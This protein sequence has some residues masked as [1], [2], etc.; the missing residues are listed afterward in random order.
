MRGSRSRAGWP[1]P[2]AGQLTGGS[3]TLPSSTPGYRFHAE[4]TGRWQ[5]VPAARLHHDP[6]AAATHHALETA[7][8]AARLYPLGEHQA[9]QA[10]I[11][12]RLGAGADL[13]DA[14]VR[15]LW[16]EVALTATTEDLAA[17]TTLER[18]LHE[19]ALN[20]QSRRRRQEEAE[21]LHQALA[22]TPTLT[23]AYWLT[24][25]PEATGSDAIAAVNRLAQ[26]ITD[27]APG[28]AWVQTARL[29]QSFVEQL[30][31]DQRANLV[32]SLAQIVTRYDQPRLAE[33]LRAITTRTAFPN[34]RASQEP[35][36]PQTAAH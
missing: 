2:R 4:L 15:L 30:D 29:L 20:E 10:H 35:P 23:L 27:H 33:D 17:A 5:E 19:E 11:N 36:G 9:A 16:A 21:E 18:R 24:H 22:A 34:G 8:A 26:Q 31:T 28:H 14:P 6:R 12:T 25:H 7:R 3:Y 13:N 32:E 1:T